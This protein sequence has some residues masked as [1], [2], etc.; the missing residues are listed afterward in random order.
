MPLCFGDIN[1]RK[2]LISL[3]FNGERAT[4]FHVVDTGDKPYADATARPL[5][6]QV[7][8]E[9]RRISEVAKLGA[10]ADCFAVLRAKAPRLTHQQRPPSEVLGVEFVVLGCVE[11][12]SRQVPA[13]PSFAGQLVAQLKAHELE[14]R[15]RDAHAT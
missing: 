2:P 7:G 9:R 6:S 14:G 13:S 11:P 4:R 5:R 10:K 12:S 3:G 8:S 15:E 1:L